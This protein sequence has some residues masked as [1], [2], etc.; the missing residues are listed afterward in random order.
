MARFGLLI[1]NE[2]QWNQNDILEDDVYYNAMITPH[3]STMNLTAICGG[4]M[5]KIA[6]DTTNAIRF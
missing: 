5:V 1:L 6:Y 4:S 2:G 3:K